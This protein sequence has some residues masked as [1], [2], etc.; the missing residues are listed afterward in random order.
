MTVNDTDKF[1]VNRSGSSYHLEAQNLMAELQDDDLM[2]V[3]RSGKSYKATGAEIKGSLKPPAEVIK[4][5]IMAP[6]NGAGSTYSPESNTIT[7]VTLDTLSG[8]YEIK[9]GDKSLNYNGH[10]TAIYNP[11]TWDS[12]TFIEN[13]TIGVRPT[14]GTSAR[15]LIYKLPRPEAYVPFVRYAGSLGPEFKFAIWGSDDGVN[16]VYLNTSLGIQSPPWS[17]FNS[18]SIPYQYFVLRQ[19][20]SASNPE[21]SVSS[22]YG[23]STDIPES[24]NLYLAG[25]KDLDTFKIGMACT[26]SDN[27]A[28]GSITEIVKA[29]DNSYV[30]MA[31]VTG[32]W[33]AGNTIIG[34]PVLNSEAGPDP[35]GV[36]FVGSTFASSDG[37]LTAGSADW[38]VTT[39][40]DTTY[41][42][43]VSSVDKHPEMGPPPTWNS[44]ELEGE[45][46]YRARTKYY[47]ASGEESPWSD[48]VTFKTANPAP[49]KTSDPGDLYFVDVTTKAITKAKLPEKVINY[50]TD[51]FSTVA[52]GLSGKV[53]IQY[54]FEAE[55]W[56]Q[57][58]VGAFAGEDITAALTGYNTSGG[59]YIDKDPPGNS[60]FVTSGGGNILFTADASD[61]GA[62]RGAEFGD[63][64]IIS[65]VSSIAQ[66][67]FVY[68]NQ[69]G[70]VKC[71]DYNRY[72]DHRAFN[73]TGFTHTAFT[74]VYDPTTN[75]GV[76]AID[77]AEYGGKKSWILLENGEL[78]HSTNTSALAKDYDNVAMI[79]PGKEFG[80]THTQITGIK[81]DGTFFVKSPGAAELTLSSLGDSQPIEPAFMLR[82]TEPRGVVLCADKTYRYIQTRTCTMEEKV[83]FGVSYTQSSSGS[84]LKSNNPSSRTLCLIIPE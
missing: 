6:A 24:Y 58:S 38:Q 66:N 35:S 22:N 30:H 1:L 50:A 3:N 8:G 21:A 64:Q 31:F 19:W 59:S 27:N 16:Y 51:S 70:Y 28:T 45:T 9:K 72:S 62:D 36:N 33:A 67:V 23:I 80:D 12:A 65:A 25:E 52:V 75:G 79:G 40:A 68:V 26:Q 20:N 32:T 81:N 39:L 37:T 42:S 55:P 77:A 53:Y 78:W 76:K 74:T 13:A 54:G 60:V 2:L 29:G 83:D 15:E 4:P 69:D 61:V 57:D 63:D 47:A 18:G 11:T 71:M 82:G 56:T 10:E 41:S 49:L 73:K 34:S 84:A 44:G 46:E 48:D 7:S 43:P 17:E 14:D 5:Q